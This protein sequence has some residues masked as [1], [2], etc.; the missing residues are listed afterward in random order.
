MNQER[1]R[2]CTR[3]G[4]EEHLQLLYCIKNG[5]KVNWISIISEVMKK[6][7]KSITYKFSYAM[8][9]S[10]F[11][12]HFKINVISKVTDNT[13]TN[14]EIGPKQLAKMNG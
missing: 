8:L 13:T 2:G 7:K 5:L 1:R 4:R 3:K 9:I 14:S 11:I 6:A 12:E 10:K